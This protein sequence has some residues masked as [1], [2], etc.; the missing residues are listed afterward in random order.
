MAKIKFYADENVSK[1]VVTGL[2]RRGV[3]VQTVPEVGTL[4]ES[5]EELLRRAKEE[6]RVIFT[7][8]DD[9]LRLAAA[10]A[11]HPG[12]VYS[13]Q[14][15]TIGEIVRGLMLIYQVLEAEEMVGHVEYL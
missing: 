1:A 15:N 14:E 9:F 7:L 5:D 11:D 8:D 13:S 2:R 4:G 10:G 3:D 12:I 6:G